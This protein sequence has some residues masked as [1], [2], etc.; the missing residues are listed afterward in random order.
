MY[1]TLSISFAAEGRAVARDGWEVLDIPLPHH[2]CESPILPTQ[3]NILGWPKS[4]F[5]RC[6]GKTRT[7]FLAN[8][9]QVTT[10]GMLHKHKE[11]SWFYHPNDTSKHLLYRNVERAFWWDQS[12]TRLEAVSLIK[13]WWDGKK[14]SKEM[15]PAIVVIW[16]E[17]GMESQTRKAGLESWECAWTLRNR[18][19]M[20]RLD[21]EG[22]E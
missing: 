3:M 4:S 17:V 2:L 22:T 20:K 13:M 9:V 21:K 19:K 12:W 11:I 10:T 5:I 7:N 1:K 6:Y 8:P 14:S 15:E 16:R 18:R